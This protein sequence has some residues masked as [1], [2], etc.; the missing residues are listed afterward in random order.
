MTVAKLQILLKRPLGTDEFDHIDHLLAKHGIAVT[1]RGAVT[2]SA[3]IPAD[4]FENVFAKRFEGRSGF[5][6]DP[7]MG[8]PLPVPADLSDHIESIT[9][10]PPHIL[11][12]H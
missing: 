5:T 12:K 10:T 6:S 2:L 1:A 11:M 3:T 7:D 8:G 4:R 9:A